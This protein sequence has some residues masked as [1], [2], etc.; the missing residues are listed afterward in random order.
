MDLAATDGLVEPDFLGFAGGGGISLDQLAAIRAIPDVELAAPVAVVG[1]LRY[2]AAAPTVRTSVLPAVPTIYRLTVTAS[3]SDGLERV[4]VRR[5]RAVVALGPADLTAAEVPFLTDRPALSWDPEGVDIPFPALPAVVSPVIGVDP[6][7][8]EALLGPSAGFLEP[9]A[10]AAVAKR[11]VAGFD[12]GLIPDEFA[13]DQATFEELRQEAVDPD[14]GSRP[15]VPLVV[16]DRIYAPL[17][18]DL[19]IDQVGPVLAAYPN[20]DAWEAIVDQERGE[21]ASGTTTVGH[22]TLDATAQMR[23]FEAPSLTLLWPGSTPPDGTMVQSGPVDDFQVRLADRPTYEARASRPGGDATTFTIEPVASDG[24]FGAPAATPP[25]GAPPDDTLDGHET[26]YRSFQ[27][28]PLAVGAGFVAHS[29]LDRPFHFAPLGTFDLGQLDLPDDPLD[30][31]PLGAYDPPRTQLVAAPDG[32]ASGPTPLSPTLDPAGLLAVPPLA[33]TD[34]AGA[35]TLRGG[36]PIDAVRVRVA[37]ISG[38]G[39][40]TVTR[41]ESV[42]SR[43]AAL[44]LDTDVV[45]GS[46]PQSVEIYVPDYHPATLASPVATDLGFVTQPWTTLGAA[47]RVDRGLSETNAVLL[48]LGMIGAFVLAA[49]LQVVRLPAVGGEVVILRAIGWRRRRVVGWA[50][51]PAMVAGV[52]VAGVAV[53]VSIS[54]HGSGLGL[55]I[56]L[57]TAGVLPLASLLTGAMA[58]RAASNRRSRAGA[59]WLRLGRRRPARPPGPTRVAWRWLTDRPGPSLTLL[60]ALAVGSAAAGISAASFIRVGAAVGP[61]LLAGALREDLSIGQMTMLVCSTFGMV[62]L[63]VLVLRQDAADRAPELRVLRAVGWSRA[64]LR[65]TL[66]IERALVAIPAAALAAIIAAAGADGVLGGDA[67]AAAL[68]ATSAAL[69]VIAWG[70]LAAHVPAG[71]R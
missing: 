22:A 5:A 37:G 46:S 61:T 57:V 38:Y 60:S 24:G 48:L 36:A 2:V 68:I 15:V 66:L 10:K 19:T 41:I 29:D 26:A 56:G 43:I 52:I 25:N 33:I 28:L 14:V 45:A 3:T 40:A 31:V 39:P 42:A 7:A 49:G 47:A 30:Y 54:T 59:R 13:V 4:L 55:A 18:L 6:Q 64:R 65:M 16:S 53:A 70:D 63:T 58:L 8:E 44:G 35:V 50:V 32:S 62:G 27:T 51:G 23:P 34:L 67:P 69:S 1:Y 12:D 20:A 21:D 71:S 9:L 11:T 17:T